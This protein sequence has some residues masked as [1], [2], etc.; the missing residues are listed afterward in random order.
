VTL[1]YRPVKPG[2]FLCEVKFKTDLEEA[3][4]VVI[5]EGVAKP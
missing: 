2:P 4:G 5:L 1:A 3:P